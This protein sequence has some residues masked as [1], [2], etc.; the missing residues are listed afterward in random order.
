MKKFVPIILLIISL[1]CVSFYYKDYIIQ[2]RIINNLKTIDKISKYKK[3]N[4]NVVS[5]IKIKGTKVDF[6]VVQY[7]DNDYYLKHSFDNSKNKYGWIF[8]DYR[9]DSFNDN[10]TIIY[11]HTIDNKLMFASLKNIL[12]D[13]SIDEIEIYEEGKFFKYKVFSVYIID[14]VNDYLRINFP[15]EEYKMFLS[16]IKKRSIYNYDI[17]PNENNK[18]LTL[19]TCYKEEKRLVIHA[20]KE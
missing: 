13:N 14:P 1:V 8:M 4:E 7:K 11:G 5:Y 20:V 17:T 6:P 15:P 9:N 16:D 2:V 3:I 19:S 10:N 12:N 18:I